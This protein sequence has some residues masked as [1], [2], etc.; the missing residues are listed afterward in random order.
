[1]DERVFNGSA[2]DIAMNR[3]CR[4]AKAEARLAGA[5]APYAVQTRITRIVQRA[6]TEY[7]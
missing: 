1:M 4:S 5:L 2:T 6:A 3:S 7:S